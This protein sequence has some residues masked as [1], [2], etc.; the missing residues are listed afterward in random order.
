MSHKAELESKSEKKLVA[1][2]YAFAIMWIVGI[3]GIVAGNEPLSGPL[4]EY[5]MGLFVL[6]FLVS[7][8]VLF[9]SKLVQM[10]FRKKAKTNTSVATSEFHQPESHGNDVMHEGLALLRNLE[11]VKGTIQNREMMEKANDIV[12]LSNSIFHKVQKEPKLISS[13]N[14]FFNYYL[15]TAIKLLTKYNDL[16]KQAIKSGNIITA[17]EKI[18]Q[19]LDTLKNAFQKQLDNLYSHTVL[20]LESDMDVLEN[21]L[22]KDGFIEDIFINNTHKGE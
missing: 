15:P 14:R 6:S 17:M 18:D 3:I 21:V 20:D 9:V 8:L 12:Q 4:F 11:A 22:K 5:F 16:E 2:I 19:T 7:M 10:I 13:M 1:H